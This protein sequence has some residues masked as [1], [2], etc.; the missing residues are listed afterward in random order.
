MS[1][2]SK[3]DRFG[4]RL[5]REAGRLFG[6]IWIPLVVAAL[7]L[8]KGYRIRG[9][10][11]LRRK[12]IALREQH[13]GP[14][15]ICA[16]HLTMV[17]SAIIAWGLAPAW[18]YVCHFSALAWNV[19]ERRNFA[20]TFINNAVVYLLKCVPIVR[21]GDR[22][23]VANVLNKIIYLLSIGEV[24]L[25][26][27][28]GGR[29]RT[30]RVEATSAAYGVGRV[31]KS[32]PGCRVLCVYLRGEGQDQFSDLPARGERFFMDISC[33]EPT[34]ELRGMRASRDL[35]GQVVDEIVAMEQKY[36]DARK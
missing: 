29:T 32:V 20:S 2:L 25:I 17:D 24:A 16:N 11:E 35:A 9:L 6:P 15:L 7:C 36:F 3:Q 10:G 1:D 26:F 30:G 12:F 4:L 8:W 31:I 18:W 5:Q 14:L 22:Q 23:D 33:I 19:P 28:E 21:G 13:D 34:T 27:P